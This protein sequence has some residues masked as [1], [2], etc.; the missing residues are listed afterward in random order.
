[1]KKVVF[2]VVAFLSA[3]CFCFG[4]N[5]EEVTYTEVG[6]FE[7]LEE[8]I[9]NGE[10]VKLTAD[11]T[12]SDKVLTIDKSIVIDLNGF[13][14]S[15]GEPGNINKAIVITG[16]DTFVTIND[17][18]DS[19]SGKIASSDSGTTPRVI[20]LESGASLILNDGTITTVGSASA[21]S[22][23]F[24]D[25]NT[26]FVM[27]GGLVEIPTTTSYS[28]AIN[29]KSAGA[30]FTMNGGEVKCELGNAISISNGSSTASTSVLI[31]DGEL[32]SGGIRAAISGSYGFYQEVTINGG[33]I[34][35][36]SVS[37]TQGSNS[38]LVITGGT[39]GADVTLN[40]T[41]TITGGEFSANVTQNGTAEITGGTFKGDVMFAMPDKL[42]LGE[43]VT[44]E[45]EP[46]F[47]VAKIGGTYY[48]DLATAISKAKEGAKIVLVSDTEVT[49]ETLVINKSLVIDL[50]GHNIS[51][52]INGHLIRIEKGN[53]EFTGEGT[54]SI[55]TAFKSVIV[56]KGSNN[57]EDVDYTTVTIG[58]D[59]TLSGW[60]GLFVTPYASGTENV[61]Y[62]VTINLNGTIKQVNG[63]AS[64]EDGGYALY[65]NGKIKDMTNAPV[66]NLSDTAVIESEGFGIY[67]AG[68]GTFNINGA[69]ISGA[70]AGIGAKSGIINF[71]DG[72]IKSTG[73]DLTPTISF[74]NGIYASGSAIQLESNAGYAGNIELVINGGKLIS[75]KGV[76]I[77]EYLDSEDGSTAV[78]KIEINDGVFSN[79][80]SKA[81]FLVSDSFKNLNSKFVK[82]GKFSNDIDNDFVATGR[83]VALNNDYYTVYNDIIS[84]VVG[85]SITLADKAYVGDTVKISDITPN[86]YYELSSIKIF[87][88]E[89]NDVTDS[90]SFD[91]SDNTFK[92]PDYAVKVVV[93]FEKI[94]YSVKGNVVGGNISLV[95]KA[96][97]GDVISIKPV[98][99][100]GY[101]LKSIQILDVETN[102]DITSTVSLNKSK[103][104][105]VMP[106]KNV[107]VNVKFVKLTGPVSSA[108]TKLYGYDDVVFSW[109]KVSG[110][111]GYL[112]YYKK[113]T[114]N[115]YTLLTNTKSLYVKR[116][117]LTDGVKYYFKVVPYVT[118]ING[119]KKVNYYKVSSIY[120]LQ[121]VKVPTVT[122]YSSNYVKVRWD[123]IPG[124][125]GYQISKSIYSNGTNIVGSVSYKTNYI[126]LK[127][128]KG[129]KYYYKVRAYK[130]VD[131]K[132]I[133]GPWSY[134]RSFILR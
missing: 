75:E 58:K 79:P 42:T 8:A 30:S 104:T 134:V 54:I 1:M 29:V 118:D 133:Y 106:G 70:S 127:A 132:K 121:K 64:F 69:L 113:S 92:V 96:N 82:A 94:N 114:S 3:F 86:K 11:I 37:L 52:A 67:I 83:S 117:D 124:E 72:I 55:S 102:K 44:F 116:A 56:V 57:V 38:T 4:V 53:V 12:V 33:V 13:T 65:I 10:N 110:A 15:G 98:A 103:Y 27:N 14:Y 36:E 111:E 32:Y 101:V 97:Y 68:Y 20:S 60:A 128:T 76:L 78:K 112:V 126:N 77:Y 34:N 35:A 59:V 131:G 71:N 107:I 120:T 26:S 9:L 95:D 63:S 28:T 130:I 123:N 7:A 49:D 81:V 25:S 100:R 105:F 18:S 47:N 43:N 5:A 21:Y 122:K 23:V 46:V 6:T 84:S 89:G 45:N 119:N 109:S 16:E 85:G 50:N 41:T 73:E 87:D 19:K 22:G 129:K 48:A 115:N 66:F 74:G 125:S 31:N 17:S 108:T 40:G 88:L 80:D 61:A 93:S 91:S 99:N 62:G 24:M 51:G 2:M 39:F 90:V